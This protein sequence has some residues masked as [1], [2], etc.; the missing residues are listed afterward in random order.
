MYFPTCVEIKVQAPF[1][2]GSLAVGVR[3]CSL[4]TV[5]CISRRSCPSLG[6][7]QGRG[8]EIARRDRSHSARS[9]ERVASMAWRARRDAV[10]AKPD[11]L[12]DFHTAWDLRREVQSIVKGQMFPHDISTRFR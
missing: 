1:N 6:R 7:N 5:E 3:C 8:A 2:L 4:D 11:S 12:V 9:E 10:D